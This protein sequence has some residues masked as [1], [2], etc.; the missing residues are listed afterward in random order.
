MRS[1]LVLLI[2]TL[3]L[4]LYVVWIGRIRRGDRAPTEPLGKRVAGAWIIGV[5]GALVALL[6]CGIIALAVLMGLFGDTIDAL[7]GGCLNC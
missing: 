4:A 7:S 1:V 6:I 3:G 5:T 2:V